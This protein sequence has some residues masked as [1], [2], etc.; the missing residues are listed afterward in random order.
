MHISVT[1]SHKDRKLQANL[2]N[3]NRF[4]TE[5]LHQ[6]YHLP[7]Q[8]INR[9]R[10]FASVCPRKRFLQSPFAGHLIASIHARQAIMAL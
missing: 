5:P 2:K 1:A 10:N 3:L 7:R 6:R 4:L 8:A 9:N